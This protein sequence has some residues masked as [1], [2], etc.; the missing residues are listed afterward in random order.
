MSSAVALLSLLVLLGAAC[1]GSDEREPTPEPS[2]TAAV[3]E[4]TPAPT[5]TPR[6]TVTRVP[7]ATP[8]PTSTPIVGNRIVI[9]RLGVNAA[10]SV[11][12]V[13]EDGA[14]PEPGSPDDV[15]MYDFDAFFFGMGGLPGQGNVV[16]AGDLNSMDYPCQD[17]TLTAPCSGVFWFLEELTPGDEI[18]IDWDGQSFRYA[19]EVLCW[20]PAEED[21]NQFAVDVGAP[22]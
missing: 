22:T 5:S 4:S 15:I 10:L 2:P 7:T 19:V 20:I 14:L 9:S 18:T 3:V 1:N 12:V 21:F 11:E 13:P 16:V 6:P 17:R 8:A